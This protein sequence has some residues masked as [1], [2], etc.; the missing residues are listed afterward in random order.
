MPQ[1]LRCYIY[2]NT[3]QQYTDTQNN[4]IPPLTPQLGNINSQKKKNTAN[5][6]TAKLKREFRKLLILTPIQPST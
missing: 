4:R 1:L 2:N 5:L 3:T 6:L